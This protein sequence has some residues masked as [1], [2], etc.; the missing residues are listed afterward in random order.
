MPN[1]T[2]RY[3]KL[4]ECVPNFSEGKDKSIIQSITEPIKTN[5]N[6]HLLD[7]DMGFDTNRTVVTFVGL[8]EDVIEVA[9][10]CIEIA[11]KLINMAQ[12][13]GEHPR[14]GA[15]DVCPLIPVKNTSMNECVRLS[16]ILSKKIADNLHI[17]IYL[18]ENSASK[19]YRKNLSSIRKG[20][21]EKFNEKIKK[22]KWKPDYGTV[23]NKK[24]GATCIGAREFLIA[25]NINL[26]TQNRKIATDIA[27]DIRESGRAKRNSEGIIL[28]D[29]NGKIIKKK[30]KF[31]YCKAVGWY[32]EE[33]NQA[34]VSINLTNYKKTSLH[35]VFDEVRKQARKRGVRVTGSEIV[36]LL[37]LQALINSGRHYLKAQN[38]PLG[39]PVS[40]I[41]DS[42]IKSLGLSDIDEFIPIDKIV[43]YKISDESNKFKNNT[44]SEFVDE[45][46]RHTPTPGGGSVS[47]LSGALGASLTA[48]VANLSINKKELS[49]NY[50]KFISVSENCQKYKEIFLDLIDKD[51]KSYDNV[52]DAMR[53]P[54]KTDSEI[55]K[56]SEM[57]ELATIGAAEVPLEILEKSISIMK[58]SLIISEHGNKNSITDVGVGAHLIKTAAYGA[59]LNV[60]INLDSLSKKRTD[61]FKEKVDYYLKEIDDLFIKTDNIV[62][63][64][65]NND[66]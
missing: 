14:M 46:S 39:L 31:N 42:A 4:I 6:V 37:P 59:A 54:K 57:I 40:D 38:S 12:H 35:K 7:V 43:D 13:K 19:K 20:E 49:E 65:I 5:P 29:D 41:I 58:Q 1:K 3:M 9:Y 15:T 63:N 34:Q 56:R 16:K 33:Y 8:P 32:I 55:K 26:N 11:S 48:M 66:K 21:Y 60:L 22:S 61:E 36:G 47:A 2:W 23:F 25:Y 52:I 50:N 64:T 17:P 24:S 18:Y 27:L 62:T 30:G 44:L 53:M 10:K 28:R 45:I 51:S